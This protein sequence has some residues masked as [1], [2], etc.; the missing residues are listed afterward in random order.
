MRTCCHAISATRA[1]HQQTAGGG[2]TINRPAREWLS[3]TNFPPPNLGQTFP[4]LF[5]P[6]DAFP[7]QHNDNQFSL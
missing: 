3:A 1:A 4:F 6:F 5:N 7:P 2:V